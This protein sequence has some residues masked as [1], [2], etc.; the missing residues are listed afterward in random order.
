MRETTGVVD[1]HD[2]HVWSLSSEVHA[3][4]AHVVVAGHPSLEE[5]QTVAEQVK[6]EIAKH[7]GIAHATLEMECEECEVPD[8]CVVFGQPPEQAE[9]Q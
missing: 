8:T 2:L 9:L 3:M 4:S 1:V 6:V 7:H 5:A